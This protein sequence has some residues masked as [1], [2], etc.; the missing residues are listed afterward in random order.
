MILFNIII[1]I[2][3]KKINIFILLN[4]FKIG[5][6]SVVIIF[7]KKFHNIMYRLGE[8]QYIMGIN[9][10]PIIEANQFNW[11]LSKWEEGSNVENKFVIIFK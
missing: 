2:R 3:E 9:K 10:I 11:R 1:N 6:N 7:I 8:I 5:F 4:G